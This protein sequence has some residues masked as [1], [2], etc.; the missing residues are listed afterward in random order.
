MKIVSRQEIFYRPK[1]SKSKVTC[2]TARCSVDGG[3]DF[4]ISLAI[5][6]RHHPSHFQI[7]G[8][9]SLYGVV[10]DIKFIGKFSNSEWTVY[11]NNFSLDFAHFRLFWMS[12][13]V[14][15]IARLQPTYYLFKIAR[16]TCKDFQ[17][18]GVITML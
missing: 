12:K 9:Y 18:Y 16:T 6:I 4:S 15:T 5:F 2:D 7:F 3:S 14:P 17:N 13:D 10:K 1:T 11:T 8:Y